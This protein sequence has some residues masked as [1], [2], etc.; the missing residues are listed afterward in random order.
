MNPRF[1][2]AAPAGG[3][4]LLLQGEERPGVVVVVCVD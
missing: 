2:N 3:T 1:K 4:R